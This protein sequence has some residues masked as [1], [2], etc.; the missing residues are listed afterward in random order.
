MKVKGSKQVGIRIT[1]GDQSLIRGFGRLLSAVQM[2]PIDMNDSDL[3]S[4]LINFSW[5]LDKKRTE[6]RLRSGVIDMSVLDSIARGLLGDKGVPSRVLAES[7]GWRQV[8]KT[9]VLDDVTMSALNE[10]SK[11]RADGNTSET[12]KI[13][14]FHT[15][16]DL[17]S[18]IAL[19]A[20]V[21]AFCVF[22]KSCIDITSGNVKMSDLKY[23]LVHIRMPRP[24]FFST[25]DKNHFE[26]VY[27]YF[28]GYNNYT[29]A[30]A[31]GLKMPEP[32]DLASSSY[33]SM[34]AENSE[35]E[36]SLETEKVRSRFTVQQ[37][38][39]NHMTVSLLPHV[40]A[41]K[42]LAISL[43]AS[44]LDENTNSTSLSDVFQEEDILDTV[45][46]CLARSDFSP[47]SLYEQCYVT[48]MEFMGAFKKYAGDLSKEGEA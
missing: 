35:S 5:S 26:K 16:R 28:Q 33:R 45:A 25:N 23:A 36:A 19:L 34:S 20:W 2:F 18:K 15:L 6:Q 1:G 17:N 41:K 29:R 46:E 48:F 44:A 3:F 22:S 14:V 21:L 32:S 47:A 8:I 39:W 12:V 43:A 10:A 40:T 7:L 30:R 38:M 24:P 31:Q 13:L 9:L 4:L 11:I 27:S 37:I 42:L